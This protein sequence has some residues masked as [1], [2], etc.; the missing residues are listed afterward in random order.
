MGKTK[1]PRTTPTPNTET[2][3]TY[4]AYVLDVGPSGPNGVHVIIVWLVV[5]FSMTVTASDRMADG[6]AHIIASNH[7]NIAV[8]TVNGFVCTRKKNNIKSGCD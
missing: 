1:I 4:W 2:G 3:F 7:I 8:I 6:I 5:L